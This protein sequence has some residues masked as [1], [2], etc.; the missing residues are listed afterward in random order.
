MRPD[1]ISL[2]VPE[3]LSRRL[4]LG[5]LGAVLLGCAKKGHPL[6]GPQAL[7]QL[8]KDIGGRVGVCAVATDSGRTLAHRADERF[9]MCSTFKWILAAAILAKVDRQE[10]KLDQRLTYTEKDLLEYAPFTGKNVARGGLTIR[11][12]TEATITVSD[13]TAANLLLARVGGP[14]GLTRFLREHGD[15]TTRLDRTEPMLNTNLDGDP[16]DTTSPRAMV[17]TLRSL[18]LGEALQP[19]SREQLVSWMVASTTG[20]TRLRAGLPKTWRVADKTGSGERGAVNDVAVAWPPQRGPILIAV[21]LSGSGF[22][23]FTSTL[24]AAHAEVGRIVA[25]NLG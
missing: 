16:R 6:D 9:A 8:E 23:T 21:Y 17:S 18:L 20:A 11:E 1:C 22:L 25:A 5:G 4:F 24:C 12:L 3:T 15:L 19:K 10:L 14:A 2:G 13:N 7:A